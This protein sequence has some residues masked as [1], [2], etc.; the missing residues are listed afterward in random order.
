MVHSFYPAKSPAFH[1]INIHQM[2]ALSSGGNHLIAVYY[3]FIDP[4]RMKG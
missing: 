3:S 1:L 4:E 2:V